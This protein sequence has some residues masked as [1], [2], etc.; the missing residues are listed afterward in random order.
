MTRR[1]DRSVDGK[2]PDEDMGLSPT[3]QGIERSGHALRLMDQTIQ[4]SPIGVAVIV[5]TFG[6]RA[7]LRM[8][9]RTW[10]VS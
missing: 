1:L 5:A 3:P 4:W 7:L 6:V 10:G 2:L 8:S 9:L